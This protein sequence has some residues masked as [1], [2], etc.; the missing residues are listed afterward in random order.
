MSFFKKSSGEVAKGDK[1]D[2]TASMPLIDDN[3]IVTSMIEE[4][5]WDDYNDER[6]LSL[7]W[8]VLDGSFKNNVAFQ[9]IKPYNPKENTAD[10][11]KETIYRLFL[12]CGATP[13]DNEPTE[14]ELMKALC[15]KPLAPRYRV[16]DFDGKKGNWVDQ[17]H[18]KVGDVEAPKAD[19]TG[20]DDDI[21]F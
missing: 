12:L 3:T 1:V 17:I 21:D 9:K 8:K 5:K 6:Y 15:N 14:M 10:A 16:W 11:A 2:T 19:D 20:V 18:K 7:K 13:P 4:A